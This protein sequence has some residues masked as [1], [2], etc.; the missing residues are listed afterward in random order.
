MIFF[1]FI[2]ILLGVFQNAKAVVPDIHELKNNDFS[3]YSDAPPVLVYITDSLGNLT[4]ADPSLPINSYGEQ[5]TAVSG[6][7]EIPNSFV[8]QQNIG[9]DNPSNLNQPQPSTLWDIEVYDGGKQT[10]TINVKGLVTASAR[11]EVDGLIVGN[12]EA[13]NVFYTLVQPGQLHKINVTFNPAEK[14]LDV[15]RIVSGNDLLKD[16]QN[17]C[18]MNLITS[19]L[20]CQ[21]LTKEAELIQDALNQKHYEEAR[22]LIWIFL[23]SL[24][25]SRPEG[26]QDPDNQA[27]VLEPALTVLKED[28]EALL[29]T[30]PKD[31]HH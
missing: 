23:H 24:G 1:I 15:Q 6:L 3:V 30:L 5:G 17:A 19:P 28:A 20:A 29:D 14:K 2:L 12:G 26:C 22:S 25:Y 16:V 27:Y 31:D 13:R 18:R 21:F 4:G 8:L 10:Y 9:S 11:I 7:N